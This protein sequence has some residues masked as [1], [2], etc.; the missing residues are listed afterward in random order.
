MY[1]FFMLHFLLERRR[2][3]Q[4]FPKC[5]QFMDEYVHFFFFVV[6]KMSDSTFAMKLITKA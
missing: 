4:H 5:Q 6:S 1:V 3:K 2:K